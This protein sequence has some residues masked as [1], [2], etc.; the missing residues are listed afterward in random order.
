MVSAQILVKIF[1]VRS[2]IDY[3]EHYGLGP[4][5]CFKIIERVLFL[6]IRAADFENVVSLCVSFKCTIQKNV[7]L[8]NSFFAVRLHRGSKIQSWVRFAL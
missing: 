8:I 5:F 6:A 7:F 1:L 4:L 3:D 2:D